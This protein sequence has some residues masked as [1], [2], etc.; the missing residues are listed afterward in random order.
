MLNGAAESGNLELMKVLVTECHLSLDPFT[1]YYAAKS[2][3]LEL[4]VYC[5]PEENEAEGQ[6][7]L[8][9]YVA[10]F[11]N[12]VHMKHL[13]KKYCLKPDGRSLQAALDNSNL[14]MV[15]YLVTE[16][17]LKIDPSMR[18]ALILKGFG[19]SRAHARLLDIIDECQ[20][21]PEMESETFQPAS[22]KQ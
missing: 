17:G 6:L 21:V 4:L 19:Q 8:I 22:S 12:Q 7:R 18:E 9:D 2:G 16:Q 1:T 13:I 15:W 3:N 14:V 10:A 11:G 5:L 20:S